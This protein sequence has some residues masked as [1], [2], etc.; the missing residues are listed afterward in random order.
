MTLKRAALAIVLSSVLA[1]AC[2]PSAQA[3][4]IIA[5]VPSPGCD[6]ADSCVAIFG[7]LTPPLVSPIVVDNTNGIAA[8]K[9]RICKQ[10]IPTGLIYGT[11]TVTLA[12][13][14]TGDATHTTA[15]GVPSAPFTF[16][17]SQPPSGSP[18]GARLIP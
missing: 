6:G 15:L 1:R 10:S 7:G 12:C 2:I 17:N 16:V 3:G 4:S 8:S 11:N 13:Q 14:I 9:F 5:D 18:S